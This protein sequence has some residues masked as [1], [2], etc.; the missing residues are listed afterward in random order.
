[1]TETT[2]Q[3]AGE[4]LTIGVLALQGAY[5]A[6]TAECSGIRQ[7]IQASASKAL[8]EQKNTG[9]KGRIIS[10]VKVF[11][12]ARLTIDL[13]F[14]ALFMAGLLFLPSIQQ[15]VFPQ[16]L[17]VGYLGMPLHH[18]DPIVMQR[19]NTLAKLAGLLGVILAVL[20]SF[21][22]FRDVL[23]VTRKLHTINRRSKP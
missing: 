12:I 6:H 8:R 4:N 2:N 20:I 17:V 10:M 1:M 23:L 5:G 7:Q 21:L 18:S 3:S 19:F 22:W 16:R 14:G 9:L 15:G 13:V 11:L